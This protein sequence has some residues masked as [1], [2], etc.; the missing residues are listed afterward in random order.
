MAAWASGLGIGLEIQSIGYRNPTMIIRFEFEHCSA[1]LK[2]LF[3]SNV[4]KNYNIS[5]GFLNCVH[6]IT[7]FT[8]IVSGTAVTAK[9]V[10]LHPAMYENNG[11]I[12]IHSSGN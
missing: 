6:H 7:L 8:L 10:V 1:V 11:D 4:N 12:V 5:M 3:A 2:S 9:V